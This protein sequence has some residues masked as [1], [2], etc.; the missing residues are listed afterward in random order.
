MAV[1]FL[2]ETERERLNSFP[3]D[4]LPDDL[5]RFFTLTA[6]DRQQIPTKTGSANRLGFALQLCTLRYLGF[7]PDKVT[8]AP[9]STVTYVA[10]QLDVS[11]GDL[12][13]YV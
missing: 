2:S 6:A 3:S 1:V 9:L 11:A 8:R 4:I 10:A 7:C 12:A 5:T 13:S